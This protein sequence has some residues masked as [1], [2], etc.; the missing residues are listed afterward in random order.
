MFKNYLKIALRNIKRHSLRSF[1]HVIGLSI[2][3]A[4]CFVIYNLVSYEYGFDTFHKEGEKIHRITSLYNSHGNVWPSSG[5]PAPLAETVRNELKEASAVTQFHT[6]RDIFVTSADKM[7]SFGKQ[8]NII[9]ADPSYFQIFSY[10]WLSGNKKTALNDGHSVVLTESSVEKYFGKINPSEAIGK[11]II[12]ADTALVTVTGVVEDLKESTD[13]IFTQFISLATLLNSEAGRKVLH[14]NNW[15][16][17]NSSTQLFVKVKP[18]DVK[19]AEINLAKINDKYIDNNDVWRTDFFIEPLK[20]LH[21]SSNYND[22][23]AD[24]AVLKGLIAIGFF[25]LMIACINFINLETAQAKLRSKEVG[26]RKTLG[27]SRN[28]LVY[29]FLTETFLII[30]LATF[31]AVILSEVAIYYFEDILPSNMVFDYLS[32]ENL[33]F[34]SL[35]IVTILFLSGF[36]PALILSAYS[37]IRALN[38]GRNF[39]A[40][41]DFHYFL[42]KNLTIIQFSLSIAFII[43]VMA[44]SGQIDFLMKKDIGFNKEAILYIHTP[45]GDPEKKNELLLN[46]LG[47][48]S[49]VKKVSNSSDILISSSVWTSTLTKEINGVKEEISIQ[50]KE[51]DT[52]YLSLYEV[53]FLAGRNLGQASNEVVINEEATKKL[54]FENAEEAI[55]S[56]FVYQEKD[57]VVVGVINNLHTESLYSAIRPML[58]INSSNFYVTNVKLNPGVDLVVAKEEIQSNFQAIYPDEPNEFKFL[59]ATVEG[60]YKSELRRQKVLGF[61]TGIAILISCLGLFGLSSFTIAQRTKE[62]SIRKVL[63]A[64]V[65]NILT[66]ITKEY[67]LLIVIAFVLSIFPAWYFLSNWLSSFQYHMELSGFT[68]LFAGLIAIVLCLFIVGLHSLKVAYSNPAD[69]L[70][71]E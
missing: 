45:Y 2:G 14:I 67:V 20:E 61:A 64:S 23:A 66:L 18:E 69:V 29:Q 57:H 13:L 51:A 70:K 28:S 53:S 27:S 71:D 52:S 32:S 8:N 46:E 39:S 22:S 16:N 12:Y 47:Q 3:I 56:S 59:D 36:Y 21:F 35:L 26:I 11:E 65:N 40:R 41:F 19:V 63:G 10:K 60:F 24:R 17:V 6:Q 1:I 44:V 48:K 50:I 30:L 7:E 58:L 31:L 15:D 49:F 42:R 62:I 9:L 37:P 43:M 68:F 5:T 4:A 55:G 34:L 33:I 54:G 38:K 25:I